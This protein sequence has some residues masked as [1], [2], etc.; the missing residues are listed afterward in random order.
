MTLFVA[1]SSPSR[2]V[3]DSSHGFEGCP[4][5][6]PCCHSDLSSLHSLIFSHKPSFPSCSPLRPYLSSWGNLKLG[7]TSRL[8]KGQLPSHFGLSCKAPALVLS[9][10][11]PY[12]STGLG[13][14]KGSRTSQ[15]G[16]GLPAAPH[17]SLVSACTRRVPV[18][19]G[20]K[21]TRPGVALLISVLSSLRS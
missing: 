10:W 19:A 2:K 18:P 12:P 15:D 4:C 13:W 8:F 6:G 17:E 7:Q 14:G 11:R 20:T 5:H 9:V 3:P 16:T 21:L 1:F